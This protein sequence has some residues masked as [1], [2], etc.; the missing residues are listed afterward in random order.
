MRIPMILLKK[1]RVLTLYSN[2][3]TS[4]SGE[5]KWIIVEM[6]FFKVPVALTALS[7]RITRP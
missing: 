7:V 5:G 6:A 1:E 2:S 3:F 4:I